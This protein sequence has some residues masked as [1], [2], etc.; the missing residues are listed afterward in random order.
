MKISKP[1]GHNQV[2]Q[3]KFQSQL[4]TTQAQTARSI[5]VESC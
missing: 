3:R 5:Y 4:F 2:I 1:L